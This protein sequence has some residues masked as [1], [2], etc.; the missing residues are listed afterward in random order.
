MT[1][2]ELREKFAFISYDKF[3]F[4]ESKESYDVDYYYTLGEF[5]FVHRLNILKRDFFHP[6]N[7]AD[8]EGRLPVI[9]W[10]IP[11]TEVNSRLLSMKWWHQR[12]VSAWNV[13]LAPE[14]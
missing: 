7:L 13:I 12:T 4:T 6:E 10:S 11:F 2:S 14:Q 9:M 5:H 3:V 8:K 1:F